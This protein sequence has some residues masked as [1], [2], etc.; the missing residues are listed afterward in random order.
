MYPTLAVRKSPPIPQKPDRGGARVLPLAR[1]P[2]LFPHLSGLRGPRPA[3]CGEV[4]PRPGLAAGTPP[5][6]A[7]VRPFNPQEMGPCR[8]M[9]RWELVVASGEGLPHPAE[10]GAAEASSRRGPMPS[11]GS[12][13][14]RDPL[15][16]L[17]GPGLSS[18]SCH[19][20]E[21]RLI[22]VPFW[23]L[24]RG[25]AGGRT[26]RPPQLKGVCMRSFILSR[27]MAWIM[28]AAGSL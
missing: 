15:R 14:L 16:R 9:P 21:G 6:L 17:A 24:H 3:P 25:I 23:D 7:R 10:L 22:A 13:V 26:R 1:L 28:A 11:L 5:A 18:D 12:H 4:V 19:A 2:Y 8:R 27:Y 20:G